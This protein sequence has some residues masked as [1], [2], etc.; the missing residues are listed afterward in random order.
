MAFLGL[1]TRSIGRFSSLRV[2]ASTPLFV[3]KKGYS[4]ERSYGNLKDSDRIFTNLYG[5]HDIFI[6]GAKKRVCFFCIISI[7]KEENINRDS[8]FYKYREIGTK[9]KK[10][11]HKVEIGL[12][13]R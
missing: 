13:M 5:E 1:S 11:Y 9:Q 8:I 12:L 7:M 6:N 2:A 10:F 3:E 4:T